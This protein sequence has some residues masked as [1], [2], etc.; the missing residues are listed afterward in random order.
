MKG[1]TGGRGGEKQIKSVTG[2]DNHSF[3]RIT[4]ELQTPYLTN[5]F[6]GSKMLSSLSAYTFLEAVKRIICEEVPQYQLELCSDFSAAMTRLVGTLYLI[7][8]RHTFQKLSEERPQTHVH[9]QVTIQTQLN[10]HQPAV[11]VCAYTIPSWMT[12]TVPPLVASEETSLPKWQIYLV[13]DVLKEHWE[14]K[15]CILQLI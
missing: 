14:G 11:G 8:L 12:I 10:V 4:S 3:R 13:N 9:L 15:C 5:C 7:Y 6:L 1:K 2:Q